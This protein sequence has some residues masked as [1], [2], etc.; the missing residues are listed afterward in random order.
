MH[1][2]EV[3]GSRCS[4]CW[5][6]GMVS[7]FVGFFLGVGWFRGVVGGGGGEGGGCLGDGL[8]REGFAVGVWVIGIFCWGGVS[9][10]GEVL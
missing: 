7:V 1:E 5:V 8:I 3:V 10:G 9:W 6:Q 4:G 2:S